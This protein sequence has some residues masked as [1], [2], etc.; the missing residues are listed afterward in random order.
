MEDPEVVEALRAAGVLAIR[1][2]R[3]LAVDA[4]AVAVEAAV[5]RHQPVISS[6][7]LL[8]KIPRTDAA[9]VLNPRVATIDQKRILFKTHPLHSTASAWVGD[10]RRSLVDR[11]RLGDRCGNADGHVA[12][13]GAWPSRPWPGSG[14]LGSPRRRRTGDRN[15]GISHRDA[16]C[17]GS[18]VSGQR[19]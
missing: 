2:D 3:V 13:N 15:A 19:S 8:D 18:H 4:E 5:S 7:L 1:A 9:V 12:N 17:R 6:P 16:G 11:H 14:S 10:H